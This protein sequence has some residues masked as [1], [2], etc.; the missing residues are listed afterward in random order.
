MEQN[1]IF[2]TSDTSYLNPTHIFALN[3]HD[4]HNLSTFYFLR[5]FFQ[6]NILS[7]QDIFKLFLMRGKEIYGGISP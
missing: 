4:F 6:K 1:K 5:F 3:K 7:K 2:Y